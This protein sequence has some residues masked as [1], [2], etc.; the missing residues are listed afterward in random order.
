MQETQEIQAMHAFS[1]HFFSGDY[2]ERPRSC[3]VCS[4]ILNID[5]QNFCGSSS[6]YS[7]VYCEEHFF[8]VFHCC[9]TCYLKN[10]EISNSS[11]SSDTQDSYS[12]LSSSFNSEKSEIY[13][14]PIED[15]M[16]CCVETKNTCLYCQKKVCEEHYIGRWVCCTECF[17]D[18]EEN[19]FAE[20]NAISPLF[21]IAPSTPLNIETYNTISAS[22]PNYNI[23]SPDFSEPCTDC[24]EEMSLELSQ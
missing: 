4:K 17:V 24:I 12:F 6:C 23:S 3:S 18:L 15:C 21:L 16:L 22:S 20:F 14:M 13:L 10:V 5:C 1:G 8:A 7:N 2:L 9:N 19:Q 11:I